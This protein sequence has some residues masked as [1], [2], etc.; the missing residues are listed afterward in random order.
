MSISHPNLV[1]LSP[2]CQPKTCSRLVAFSMGIPLSAEQMPL[3]GYFP[4]DK[5]KPKTHQRCGARA[6]AKS[7]GVENGYSTACYSNHKAS[8]DTA[9][10]KRQ[11]KKQYFQVVEKY[12]K[13][14][15]N[16]WK[17]D[18]HPDLGFSVQI[19]TNT[20]LFWRYLSGLLQRRGN[21][22]FYGK[23]CLQHSP[24]PESNSVVCSTPLLQTPTCRK[25]SGSFQTSAIEVPVVWCSKKHCLGWHKISGEGERFKYVGVGCITAD[26]HNTSPRC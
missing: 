4:S 15:E 5:V 6:G 21:W 26:V 3:G 12:W 8:H 10:P 25:H 20:V 11:N 2:K 7:I 1:S 14:I 9:E 16:I 18:F 17:Q 23:C 13:C 22:W 19:Q 24:T